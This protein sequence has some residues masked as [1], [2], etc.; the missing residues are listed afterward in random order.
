MSLL[1]E[2]SIEGPNGRHKCLVTQAAGCSIAQSKE[3]SNN[4]M[5]SL[6]RLLGQF[7]LKFSWDWTLFIHPGL[8][9]AV[10]PDPLPQSRQAIC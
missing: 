7:R 3:A 5:C 2:F 8:C 9:T 1:D 4:W 6:S 10:N